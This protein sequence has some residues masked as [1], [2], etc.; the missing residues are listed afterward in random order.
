M[1]QRRKTNSS[2]AVHLHGGRFDGD[3]SERALEIMPGKLPMLGMII[4]T[5]QYV[6]QS[7][8]FL[9]DCDDAEVLDM[10]FVQIIG[11]DESVYDD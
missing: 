1:G 6:Y 8:K 7:R 3:E 10:D 5:R 2:A 11:K 9:E 4:G